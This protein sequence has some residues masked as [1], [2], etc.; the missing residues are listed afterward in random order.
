MLAG[1]R[2]IPLTPA[3]PLFGS[4]RCAPV[5]ALD[6]RRSADSSFADSPL[7]RIP[8]C[9]CSSYTLYQ[10]STKSLTC[11]HYRTAGCEETDGRPGLFVL[12]AR[13]RGGRRRGRRWSGAGFRRR[14][15]AGRPGPGDGV[16]LS[17]MGKR[18]GEPDG[19]HQKQ[20]RFLVEPR[21]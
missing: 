9:N 15:G 2:G 3:A 16:V 5:A 13:S 14:H 8:I 20:R 11:K 17:G 10:T 7:V 4:K 6:D 1:G 12:R 21:I 19:G 18:H